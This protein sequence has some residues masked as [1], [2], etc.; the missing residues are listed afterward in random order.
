MSREEV[1]SVVNDA[2]MS[3]LHKDH[4]STGM[5]KEFW[6]SLRGVF[7]GVMS[8][9]KDKAICRRASDVDPSS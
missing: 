2:T 7:S 9:C 1:V 5:K 6:N 8:E 4:S 3:K